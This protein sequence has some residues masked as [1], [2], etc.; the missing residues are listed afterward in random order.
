MNRYYT[1][2]FVMM[3]SS[4]SLIAQTPVATTAGFYDFRVQDGQGKCLSMAD[5]KGKTLLVVNVASKCGYTKQ[6]TP[7]EALYKKY[8]DQGFIILGFPC[9]QFANQEPGT[10]EEIQAFCQ[11]NYGVTFPIMSKIEVNGAG[12][13]PLYAYLKDATGGDPI[14]W[15]FNKFLIDKQG[16]VIKRYQSGDSLE[17]LEED[18]K[19]IL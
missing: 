9:N 14:R 2:L 15:N 18:L 19:A 12:T 10:N 16:S 5:F 11:L 6:Y 8:K 1:L 7:L 17:E 13:H 4:L 3:L